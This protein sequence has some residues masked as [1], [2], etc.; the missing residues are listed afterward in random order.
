MAS[1][2]TGLGVCLPVIMFISA[3]SALVGMGRRPG[4]PSAWGGD[5]EEANEILG[6]CTCLLL[7]LRGGDG[8]IPGPS[9]SPCSS[10]SA[11]AENTMG[12]ATDYLEIYLWGTIAVQLALGLNNFIT[13]QGFSTVSMLTVVIGAVCNI[14]LD[15]IFIF[16]FDMG[17]Q[18]AALATII[19]QAVSAL[20][21]LRF[22]HWEAVQLTIQ[23]GHLRPGPQSALLC[24][25]IGV[26][27]PSS[28]SPP[29]A[30]STSPFNSSLSRSTAATPTWGPMTIASCIMQVLTMPFMGLTQGPSP[31]WASTT[32]QA[33]RTGSEGPSSCSSSGIALSTVCFLSVQ[34]FPGAF[35]AIFN[36]KAGAGPGRRVALHVYFR[37]MFMLGMQFSLPADLRG[38][39]AEPRSP[40]SWPCCGRSSFSSL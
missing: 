26:S 23:A 19:P 17:V 34:L 32:A 35:I 39:G 33:R 28:C 3:L 37:G 18:G 5:Q 1:W 11:P 14:V 31:S 38:P 27:P 20:W 30:W 9:R 16:G 6:N 24:M 7:I 12:Y 2:L 40:F 10:S 22:P 4:R 13:T 25:A 29:R 36:D 8:G 21:V 15:P